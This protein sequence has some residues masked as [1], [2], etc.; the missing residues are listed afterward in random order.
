MEYGA[1]HV[2]HV[3]L[4]FNG[5]LRHIYNTNLCPCLQCIKQLGLHSLAA[6]AHLGMQS[7]HSI[8]YTQICRQSDMFQTLHCQLHEVGQ[9]LTK[10]ATDL[11]QCA[12]ATVGDMPSRFQH[13]CITTDQLR[14]QANVNA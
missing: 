13:S 14:Y 12:N 4:A 11:A 9:D 5:M 2:M 6:S 10:C 8:Q 7:T 3:C 1:K